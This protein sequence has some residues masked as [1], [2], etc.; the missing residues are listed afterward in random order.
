MTDLPKL[1]Q[2]IGLP[3]TS[4]TNQSLVVLDLPRSDQTQP[5]PSRPE[6]GQS[7]PGSGQPLGPD[8]TVKSGD[9]NARLTA[10][11]QLQPGEKEQ[12]AIRAA[13]GDAQARAVL[14][15]SEQAEALGVPFST[16]AIPLARAGLDLAAQYLPQG[17]QAQQ[18]ATGARR[19]GDILGL[20]Q[21]SSN[22]TVEVYTNRAINAITTGRNILRG[23]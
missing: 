10:S 19:I 13:R 16:F 18:I 11:G 23:F 6:A 5:L 22:P 21:A 17:S 20:P 12:L 1:P 2:V 3:S 7:S 15:A 14:Q 8:D 9:P 4:R